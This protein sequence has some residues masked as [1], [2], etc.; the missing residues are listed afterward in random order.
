MISSL[1]KRQIHFFAQLTLKSI[2]WLI[3]Q[4]K[5][6]TIVKIHKRDQVL[7]LFGRISLLK[8]PELMLTTSFFRVSVNT[9]NTNYRGCLISNS[10][11][12]LFGYRVSWSITSFWWNTDFNNFRNMGLYKEEWSYKGNRC[13]S[14]LNCILTVE[15]YLFLV[16]EECSDFGAC[17]VTCGDGTKSCSNTCLHGDFGDEGCPLT[18]RERSEACNQQDCPGFTP[19][20]SDFEILNDA[21]RHGPCH[22]KDNFEILRDNS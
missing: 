5:F 20:L 19:S 8:S 11:R 1:R 17:S 9:S 16:V 22:M 18:Q 15:W 2:L 12:M 6:A 4:C 14:N 10:E 21:E 13:I 3:L 7:N